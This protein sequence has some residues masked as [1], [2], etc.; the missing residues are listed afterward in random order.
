M[1]DGAWHP[2]APDQDFGVSVAADQDLLDRLVT[3]LDAALRPRPR[4]GNKAPLARRPVGP[5]PSRGWTAL[6]V[7]SRT[8]VDGPVTTA[9]ALDAA[10]EIGRVDD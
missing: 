8:R 2:Y 6:L 10:V 7:A 5:L 9:T 4:P 1:G 3:E